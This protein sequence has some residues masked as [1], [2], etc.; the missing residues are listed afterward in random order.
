MGQYVSF[1]ERS[2]EL[3][4]RIRAQTRVVAIALSVA[5]RQV[6]SLDL[7]LAEAE[8]LLERLIAP[9]Q[10]ELNAMLESKR[11]TTARQATDDTAQ[12]RSAQLVE[13][14]AMARRTLDDLPPEQQKQLMAMI[15]IKVTFLEPSRRRRNGQPCAKAAGFAERQ[16]PVPLLTDEGWTKIAPMI[17][18]KPRG[19]SPR[20]VMTGILYRVRTGASWSD[21]PALFG[22]TMTLQTY[23]AR[24]RE[25]GLWETAMQALAAAEST[26]LPTPSQLRT[27]VECSIEPENLLNNSWSS[28]FGKLERR[29]L[30]AVHPLRP[31]RLLLVRRPIL[32]CWRSWWC[33]PGCPPVQRPRPGCA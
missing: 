14:A 10:A 25:S 28:K 33:G 29:G 6:A 7:C 27:R 24:W 31:R 15:D 9:V 3:D 30:P 22:H 1:E 19:V 26:R 4:R 23:S 18:H 16:L 13:L 12:K 11:E 8:T 17:T 21:L 5:V 20:L 2:A 32:R